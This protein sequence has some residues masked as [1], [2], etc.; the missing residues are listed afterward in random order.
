MVYLFLADGFEEVEALT[1]VDVLRR[2]GV[3]LKTVSIMKDLTVTGCHDVAVLA[4]E[5]FEDVDY[6][7]CEMMILPGGGPGTQRLLAHEGLKTAL[8]E[9]AAAGKRIA[10]ICAAPMVLARHGLL[11]GKNATVYDGMEEELTGAAAVYTKK[12]VVQDGKIITSRG[13][14]TAMAFAF[15]LAETLAGKATADTVRSD[16]LL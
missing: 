12:D 10:A 5:L 4:D 13:P 14:G 6:V 1:V 15:A 9:F 16:M 2:A 3:S 7:Q 11:K 8:A